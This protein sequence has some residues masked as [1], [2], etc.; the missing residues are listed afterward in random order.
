VTELSRREF[1]RHECTLKIAYEIVKWNECH[2]DTLKRPLHSSS[3]NIS[4]SGIGL[5]HPPEFDKRTLKHLSTGSHKIR[6]GLYLSP[7]HTQ[8]PL[9]L[10]ARLI[11][12][13]ENDS[14]SRAGFTFIDIS[15]DSFRALK[16][17]LATLPETPVASNCSP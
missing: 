8:P 17:Y 13:D 16:D 4:L 14:S 10:F 11:W 15:M 3:F 2:L 7:E 6:L 12:S 1:E 9:I 5:V